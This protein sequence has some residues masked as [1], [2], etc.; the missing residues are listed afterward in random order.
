VC[1]RGVS[2]LTVSPWAR[3]SCGSPPRGPPGAVR[4]RGTSQSADPT[5]IARSQLF[6]ATVGTFSFHH[7]KSHHQS[8]GA[9]Q[10]PGTNTVQTLLLT[11]GIT[12]ISVARVQPCDC[13]AVPVAAA[14][15]RFHPECSR[16]GK[17]HYGA[18]DDCPRPGCSFGKEI[19][20][21]SS[22]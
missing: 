14:R 22:E 15:P 8:A 4:L 5:T 17:T 19:T 1:H 7:H 6:P 9:S 11:A 12:V 13:D 3:R 20:R 21:R 16:S 10:R 18:V 2:V